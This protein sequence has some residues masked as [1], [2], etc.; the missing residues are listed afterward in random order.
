MHPQD[1]PFSGTPSVIGKYAEHLVA[2]PTCRSCG[3][4][5][6][7]RRAGEMAR[8]PGVRLEVE[9]FRCR[10]GRGSG[11]RAL[12]ELVADLQRR[13]R[14]VGAENSVAP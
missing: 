6:A 11:V 7:G 10:S 9:V 13:G 4:S 8:D 12:H 2:D 5:L 14:R 3:S 1:S